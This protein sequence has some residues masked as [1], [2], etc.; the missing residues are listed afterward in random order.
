[1]TQAESLHGTHEPTDRTPPRAAGSIRRTTTMDGLYP[2]GLEGPLLLIGRGR[3]LVTTASGAAEV[4]GEAHLRVDVQ[5]PAGPSIAAIQVDPDVAGVGGLIGNTP[6]KG[7]RGLIDD[8]TSASRGSL[9]YLLLDD[10]PVATLVSGYA[11]HVLGHSR[12]RT[13]KWRP[14]GPALQFPNLCAGYQVGGVIVTGL[15]ATTGPNL[16]QSG[17]RHQ[18]LPTRATRWAGMTWRSWNPTGSEGDAARM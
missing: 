15:R 8:T 16:F 14:A 3:D 2:E 5:F 17:Q 7:F 9:A 6:S 18:T 10:I 12:T 11:L 4:I 1:M 13:S